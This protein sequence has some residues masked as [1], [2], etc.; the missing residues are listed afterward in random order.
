MI[1]PLVS[2][3]MLTEVDIDTIAPAS[4]C[5]DSPAS[6][7]TV[8][9]ANAGL[10]VTSVRMLTPVDVCEHPTDVERVMLHFV[11]GAPGEP[12]HGALVAVAPDRDTRPLG[13]VE[14]GEQSRQY[15]TVDVRAAAAPPRGSALYPSRSQAS[16]KSKAARCGRTSLSVR[17]MRSS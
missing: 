3:L 11:R 1:P 10:N 15:M 17:R 14:R 4:A 13:G 12:E 16:W 8:A 9:M 5:T 6:N 7:V 2:V